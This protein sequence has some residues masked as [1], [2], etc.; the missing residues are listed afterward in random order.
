[1]YKKSFGTLRTY[2]ISIHNC[3]FWSKNCH[4]S[5]KHTNH[6]ISQTVTTVGQKN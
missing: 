1:M 2:I 6:R 3:I 5:V 4:L